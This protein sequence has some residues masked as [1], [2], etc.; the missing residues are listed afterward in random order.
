MGAVSKPPFLVYRVLAS[1]YIS[2]SFSDILYRCAAPRN[3]CYIVNWVPK[4]KKKK[5]GPRNIW[6]MLIYIWCAGLEVCEYV[7][8]P[9]K[10]ARRQDDIKK[11]KKQQKNKKNQIKWCFHTFLWATAFHIW[12]IMWLLFLSPHLEKNQTYYVFLWR[13]GGAWPR[14]LSWLSKQTYQEQVETGCHWCHIR[15]VLNQR[16]PQD[17]YLLRPGSCHTMPHACLIKW[18]L[19]TAE[20][21]AAGPRGRAA[22]L[23]MS[24]SFFFLPLLSQMVLVMKR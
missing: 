16:K 5:K 15:P 13:R 1:V 10:E 24:R 11:I 18:A 8:S 12:R 17:M 9:L 14:G 22:L 20:W 6:L 2:K 21:R 3:I 23:S 7:C 19:G 4:A